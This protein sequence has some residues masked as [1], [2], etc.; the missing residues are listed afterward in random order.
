MS[1]V[2]T[3]ERKQTGILSSKILLIIFSVLILALLILFTIRFTYPPGWDFRNNLWAPTHLLVNHQSPYRVTVL[4]Q[5]VTAIWLPM[6]LGVFWPMGYLPLQQ[7]SNL[8]WVINLVALGAIVWLSS[9]VRRPP[10]WLLILGLLLAFLF[11]ATIAH[12]SLGQITIL[13]CLVFVLISII[14]N[15]IH[16]LVFGFLLAFSLTKPQ[17]ALLVL[18][19]FFIAYTKDFGIFHSIRL[20][21]YSLLAGAITL[22]PLFLFYPQWLPDL[23]HNLR[24]NPAWAHPSSLFILRSIFADFGVVLWWLLLVLISILN[25][26]LWLHL[27]KGEA[28][29]WSLALTTLVTPYIWSWDFV[30]L[31][32]LIINYLQ[33]KRGNSRLFLLICYV[34]C[35][36]VIAYMKFAGHN[37]EELYWWVPWYFM[38][39]IL[40]LIGFRWVSGILKRKYFLK[41]G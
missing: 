20:F 39:G 3:E 27:S 28:I 1:E 4:Y 30:L 26:W 7:A 16:P 8:W 18:P 6:A 23:I 32:P 40:I 15:G 25:L 12:F 38:G 36:S 37:A 10:R 29:V 14:G 33:K 17:L 13:I 9:G 21:L 19:G 11:P 2:T 24:N 41:P 35:W 34:L 5:E 22:V 31:L